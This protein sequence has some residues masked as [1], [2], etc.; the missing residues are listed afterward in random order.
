[1]R[2]LYQT[3][4]HGIPFETFSALSPRK[5][6]GPEF[7]SAFYRRLFQK[8]T[9]PEQLD[10]K[11]LH[12][13]RTIIRALSERYFPDR[14]TTIL[15]IGCGLGI[16]EM[17]LIA[18]G[19]SDV[20]VT[21]I[22]DTPL[23]W[24]R[25]VLPAER[26]HIGAFPAGLPSMLAF[27]VILLGSADYFLDQR[28]LRALLQQARARIHPHGV[29]IIISHSLDDISG[30]RGARETVKSALRRV[31]P[32]AAQWWGYLR[33]RSEYKSALRQAGFRV[34][35]DELMDTQTSWQS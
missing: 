2:R 11:W 9:A 28:E 33:T 16:M 7:Y 12:L 24:L 13:K 15:S 5:L 3:S 8:H 18:R 23:K 4:W 20:H 35:S 6:P 32:P 25:N 10:A 31:R 1:M 19:Y 26:I 21:E 17:D 14:A 27:D 29:A 34:R 30:W 22:S